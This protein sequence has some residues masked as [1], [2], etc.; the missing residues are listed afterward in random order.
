MPGVGYELWFL[1]ESMEF[2]ESTPGGL[3]AALPPSDVI[4]K[5]VYVNQPEGDQLAQARARV[6]TRDYWGRE[7]IY[8]L[9]P[10]QGTDGPPFRSVLIYRAAGGTEVGRFDDPRVPQSHTFGVLRTRAVRYHALRVGGPLGWE[11]DLV[12]G[13]PGFFLTGTS[14]TSALWRLARIEADALDRQV[15]TLAPVR[16]P[17][18]IPM[19]H[20]EAVADSAV[21]Q[22][23]TEQFEAFRS[24]VAA[25]AHLAVVD[26]AANIAEA[27]LAHCLQQIGRGVPDRLAERL[28]EAKAV[29][30][31][32]SRRPQ[33]PLSDYGY[34]L[35]Q[36]IR[37]LHAQVHED[38]ARRRGSTVRPEVGLA[39]ATDVGELLV[40]V[41]LAGY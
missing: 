36:K 26:R 23:L 38:Q 20:F 33:F 16:L 5:A 40:E 4:F 37:L 19:S 8:L 24:A 14:G 28:Q 25:G 10:T 11:T 34:H 15:L 41:K 29:L 2:G 13:Q 21:R 30:E 12:D 32:K 3:V 35:A 7:D 27:V 1:P 6:A 39:V 18:A 17:H 31:D 22:Y 9:R